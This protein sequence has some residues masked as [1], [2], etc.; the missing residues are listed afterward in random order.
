[1]EK[2]FSWDPKGQITFFKTILGL[3]Q[4]I[5]CFLGGSLNLMLFLSFASN[6]N[7]I[8]LNDHFLDWNKTKHN[9]FW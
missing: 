4:F 1:M 3:Q 6:K 8:H 5:N 7:S 2:I 9:R